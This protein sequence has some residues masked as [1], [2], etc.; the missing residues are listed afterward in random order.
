MCPTLNTL[1]NHSYISRDSIT[2][3]AEAANAVQTDYRFGYGVSVTSSLVGL[4][5]GGDLV[6]GKYSIG[7]ANDRVPNAPA[8]IEFG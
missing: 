2:S 8:S 3:L 1:A 6:T 4:L 5:A 7:G